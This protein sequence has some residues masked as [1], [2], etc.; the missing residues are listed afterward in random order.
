MAILSDED[1]KREIGE[2]LY[3]APFNLTKLKGA[4]Y[5]LTASKLAWSLSSKKSIYDDT[6]NKI[7]IPASTTALIETHEVIWVSQE[8]CGSYHSKVLQVSQGTGHIGTTLDPNYIGFSL[9]AVHNHSSNPIELVPE[10]DEFV[11]IV[12]Q[13]LYTKSSRELHGN[14]SGRIEILEQIGIKLTDEERLVFKEDFT[15]NSE[16]L[17]TK[18]EQCEDYK[19]IKGNR[20]NTAEII[21]VQLNRK[22][23]NFKLMLIFFGIIGASVILYAVIANFSDQFWYASVTSVIDKVIP[24]IIAVVFGT[25]VGLSISPTMHPK[26]K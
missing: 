6:T 24:S 10:R 7:I 20:E 16:T 17:K 18:M 19:K 22:S 25:W 21:Q 15:Y 3:I 23:I 8:I 9:I 12:F 4:S 26:N 2:K 1:I 13:Y 11:T 5:N 14:T